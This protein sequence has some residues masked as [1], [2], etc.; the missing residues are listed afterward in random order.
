MDE[1]YMTYEREVTL[2]QV[3]ENVSVICYVPTI[4]FDRVEKLMDTKNISS[5][6]KHTIY[7]FYGIKQGQ[8]LIGYVKFSIHTFGC[9]VEI[10]TINIDSNNQRKG[11][12]SILLETSLS[13]IVT[14][15]PY[16]EKMIVT[17]TS[18]AIPFYKENGFI[19]YFGENNLERKL[20]KNAERG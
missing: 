16:L 7:R 17:S 8:N 13:D 4:F 10:D 18:D 6:W 11:L 3:T 14:D 19:P 15:F 5:P 20:I 2:K 1:Y 9:R 12:G